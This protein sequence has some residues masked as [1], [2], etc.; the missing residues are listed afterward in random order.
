MIMKWLYEKLIGAA[1][2]AYHAV[3]HGSGIDSWICRQCIKI[4]REDE[5]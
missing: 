1:D 2:L 5:S 3:F 4:L